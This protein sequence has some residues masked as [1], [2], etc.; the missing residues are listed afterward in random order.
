[1]PTLHTLL[2]FAAT[3]AALVA[4]PGPNHLYIAT[5]AVAQGR[6]AGIVSGLGVETGTLVHIAAAAG[7]LSALIASSATAFDAVRYAGA[8]YLVLLGVRALRA[9]SAG[10]GGEA[11]PPVPVSLRRVYRDGIVVNVLNPKVALFFLAF[12]P[13]FLDPE[14]GTVVLQVVTL[15]LVL[16]A[17]GLLSNVVCAVAADRVARRLRA[18]SGGVLAGR[19]H[20][21]TGGIYVGLGA[22]AALAG[23]RRHGA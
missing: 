11:A 12:L 17:L 3:A 9:G 10:T 14:R 20:L 23:G 4:I 13:Q 8:A 7:G 15:G 22:V 5:R 6:R 1:M 2:L 18:R 16:A 21:L 19:G